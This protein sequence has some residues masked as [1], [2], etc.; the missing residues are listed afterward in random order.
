[1]KMHHAMRA[2]LAAGLALALSGCLGLGGAKAPPT[3][4]TLAPVATLP[5]GGASAGNAADAIVVLVPETDRAIGVNRVAV[6]IDDTNFAY[7]KKAQWIER[8]ARLFGSLL[9][10]T[11]RAGGRRLVFTGDD[12][13]ASGD[14]R[15]GGRLVDFGYDA[16][17]QSAV[18]RFDAVR[19]SKGGAISTKRFEASVPGVTATPE[20]VGPALN[21]AANQVAAEVAA[22]VG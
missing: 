13:M 22:W 12:A 11:I 19:S 20:S 2:A 4:L 14:T 15:L 21:K 10:E 8:P 18:V 5:A 7:L 16:R 3:L 6:R 1:M 9:A 17:S